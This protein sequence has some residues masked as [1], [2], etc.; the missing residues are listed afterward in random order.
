MNA[1]Q[2]ISAVLSAILIVIGIVMVVTAV[3]GGGGP[4]SYGVVVGVLFTLAGAARLWLATK[5]G[6]R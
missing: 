4:L 5:G 3:S 6:R 2:R 1:H